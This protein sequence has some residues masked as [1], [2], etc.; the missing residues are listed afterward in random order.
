MSTRAEDR[1]AGI[2]AHLADSR[3]IILDVASPYSLGEQD[4]VFLG[5]WSAADLLAHLVG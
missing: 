5:T 1:K 2:I 3:R 4:E